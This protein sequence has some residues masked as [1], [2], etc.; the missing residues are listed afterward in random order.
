MAEEIRRKERERRIEREKEMLQPL[1]RT[2][3][4]RYK[5]GEPNQTIDKSVTKSGKLTFYAANANMASK[6]IEKPGKIRSRR[7]EF[8]TLPPYHGHYLDSLLN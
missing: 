8:S 2:T 7:F 1:Q 6:S 4:G 3:E 5:D